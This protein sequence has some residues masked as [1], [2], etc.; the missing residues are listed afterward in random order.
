MLRNLFAA[1]GLQEKLVFNNGPQLVST[2]FRQFLGRNGIEHAAGPTYHPASNGAAE[3]SM[4][5][6]KSALMEG[7]LEADGKVSLPLSHRL[8][9]F[10]PMYANAKSESVSVCFSLSLPEEL[11]RNK[12]CRNFIMTVASR[13][14]ISFRRVMLY[15]S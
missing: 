3:R 8:A 4:Q 1:Y 12:P 15:A 9:N 2:E 7:V 6:L 5:I 13:L 11:K 14:S 10:L